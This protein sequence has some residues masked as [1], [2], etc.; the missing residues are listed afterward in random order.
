MTKTVRENE[1]SEC[2]VPLRIDNM[3]EITPSSLSSPESSWHSHTVR[4]V[5]QLWL[6]SG[7]PTFDR[8]GVRFGSVLSNIGETLEQRSFDR[9]P[10]CEQLIVVNHI[11]TDLP[12]PK[13]QF[14]LPSTNNAQCNNDNYQLP[15]PDTH[16]TKPPINMPIFTAAH[17]SSTVSKKLTYEA[18]FV[19]QWN[20]TR[21]KLTKFWFFMISATFAAFMTCLYFYNPLYIVPLVIV[22]G[23]I[24]C[25]VTEGFETS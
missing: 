25:F 18:D 11:T 17:S 13:H 3:E 15:I 23:L 19:L 12:R 24:V 22:Y 14:Y 4:S 9:P 8:T 2:E 21:Q 7:V 20:R 5:M 10:V 1:P 16:N 6:N